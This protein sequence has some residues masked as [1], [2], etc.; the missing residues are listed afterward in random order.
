MDA[1]TARTRAGL[2]RPPPSRSRLTWCPLPGRLPAG[3]PLLSDP[4][5]AGRPGARRRARQAASSPRGPD[6]GGAVTM[7]TAAASPAPEAAGRPEERSLP[8]PRTPDLV[9]HRTGHGR[10]QEPTGKWGEGSGQGA[11]SG[12]LG[13]RKGWRPRQRAP[14]RSGGARR[15]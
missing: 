6:A 7:E 12:H 3:P 15:P 9:G 11:F 14:G 4:G 8:P 13:T 10:S 2:P 5:R 1:G